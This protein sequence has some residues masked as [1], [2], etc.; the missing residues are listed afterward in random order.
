MDNIEFFRE[1]LEKI[2]ELPIERHEAKSV[3]AAFN[4]IALNKS[5]R[6]TLKKP[7]SIRAH[8][9]VDEDALVV[10]MKIHSLDLVMRKKEYILEKI[11]KTLLD[12]AIKD[13]FPEIKKL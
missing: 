1:I 4:I 9:A 12:K 7:I 8:Q 2:L 10:Q 13:I 6:S 3:I 11:G 5:A